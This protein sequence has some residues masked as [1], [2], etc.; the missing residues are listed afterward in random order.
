M[1]EAD[2]PTEILTHEI[3][4]DDDSL[5]VAVVQAVSAASNRRPRDL[6]P[7]EETIGVDSLE[8]LSQSGSDDPGSSLEMTFRYEGYLVHIDGGMT[9]TIYDRSG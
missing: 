3:G 7:L 5:G 8:S 1:T 2:L 9:V 4:P 6:T